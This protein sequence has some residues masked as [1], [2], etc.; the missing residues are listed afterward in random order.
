MAI[1][2]F[3]KDCGDKDPKVK[4]LALR[5]LC[6]LRFAGSSEYLV[7]AITKALMDLDGY[8]RK[9]AVMGCVKVFYMNPEAVKSKRLIKRFMIGTVVF[10]LVDKEMIDTLYKMVKDPDPLVV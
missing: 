4:G 8:V 3:V 7:P 6:S 1:N 5:S 10:I 2:T 9:T